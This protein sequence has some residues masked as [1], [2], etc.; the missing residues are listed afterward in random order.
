[1][2][3]AQQQ[4]FLDASGIQASELNEYLRLGLGLLIIVVSV[5]IL[6]GLLKLLEDGHMEN[7]LRFLMYLS[8]LS[9]VLMLFF[10]F[11]VS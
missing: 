2:T 3:P 11:V 8:T 10:S 1:M 5:F 6:V 9:V 7:R 4:A